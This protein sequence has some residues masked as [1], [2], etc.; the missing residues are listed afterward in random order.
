M[1]ENEETKKAREECYKKLDGIIETDRQESNKYI[2]ENQ[3]AQ[4]QMIFTVSAALFALMPFLLDKV[5]AIPYFEC[6]ILFLLIFNFAAIISTLLSFEF[7]KKGIKENFEIR[8]QRVRC[9]KELIQNNSIEAF[10]NHCNDKPER[11]CWAWVGMICNM[12][13]L[14]SMIMVTI[15]VFSVLLLYLSNKEINMASQN[16]NGSQQNPSVG[17]GNE[18]CIDRIDSDIQ[19]PQEL[20][21]Q[22][23][24]TKS[25]NESSKTSKEEKDD[26]KQ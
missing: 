8:K 21:Q 9:C 18:G 3:K 1:D 19:L 20:L 25:D 22:L 24:Q 16:N 2:L 12:V 15:L 23:L 6:L 10:E 5:Q 14:A 26:K 4:D 11:S 13:S 17:N 7:C